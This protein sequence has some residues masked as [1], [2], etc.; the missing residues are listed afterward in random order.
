MD[1]RMSKWLLG[2]RANTFLKILTH[3]AKLASGMVF[4]YICLPEMQGS[5]FPNRLYNGGFIA[6]FFL[7]P[8]RL[9]LNIIFFCCFY[10]S[11][12]F[13]LNIHPSLKS[14]SHSC[15]LFYWRRK[16]FLNPSSPLHPKS[17]AR[18][19][20]P[21]WWSQGCHESLPGTEERTD[22]L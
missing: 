2:W 1:I 12:F 10:F 3:V 16:S 9:M 17:L 13:F 15:G 8:V 11:Y 21:P 19:L 4:Q 6:L 18:G 22:L 20:R 5:M 7:L 14:S